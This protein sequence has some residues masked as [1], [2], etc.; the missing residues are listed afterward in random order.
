MTTTG[1]NLFTTILGLAGTFLG[2][3]ILVQVIQESWKYV[4][5]TKSAAYERAL[6]QFIGPWA[7]QLTRPGILADLQADGPFQV[8]RRRPLGKL[9]PLEKPELVEA[10]ERTAPPWVRRTL[11]ALRLE[12]ASA[13]AVGGA[14]PPTPAL[15]ALSKELATAERGSPGF[16]TAMDIM[17]F[18]TPWQIQIT[19][20]SGSTA[21]I[22][23]LP[24]SVNAVALLAAF[25]ERFLAHVTRA[26]R[27]F[28]QLDRNF[29]YIYK[30]RNTL[31]TFLI[32]I[33]VTLVANLPIGRLLRQA[34][35]MTPE[36]A[37]TLAENMT[38]LY[39]SIPP[40]NPAS[41]SARARAERVRTLAIKALETGAGLGIDPK[42]GS[43]DDR[44][45][46]A[47]IW[48]Q[49][50]GVVAHVRKEGALYLAECLVTALLI[51]FGAP[52]WND[53]AGTMLRLQRGPPKPAKAEAE[54]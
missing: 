40:G 10:M 6:L 27:T 23:S 22:V 25:R 36:Q 35:A 12:G 50:T 4:L 30:R 34:E 17:S 11:D 42:L 43:P 32:A 33:A 28:G 8:W 21:G 20:A 41:D 2:L 16:A 19:P 51:S 48:A 38:R 29:D 37:V 46:L 1:S 31:L 49:L 52:F 53:L 3:A 5:S 26:E 45:W 13:S 24:P 44:N 15:A 9:L 7:R 18:L 14:V 39:D 54:G 47:G